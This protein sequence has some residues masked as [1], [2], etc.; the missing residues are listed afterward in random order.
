MKKKTE[1][2]QIEAMLDI[3][4]TAEYLGISVPTVRRMIKNKKIQASF[5]CSEGHGRGVWRIKKEWI[6]KY[7]NKSE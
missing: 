1:G 6:E 7:L 5:I 3:K 2:Q 4:Q